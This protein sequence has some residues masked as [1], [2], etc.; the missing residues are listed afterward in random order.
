MMAKGLVIPVFYEFESP[1]YEEDNPR[2]LTEYSVKD[3]TFYNIDCTTIYEDE[4]DG[5]RKYGRIFSGGETFISAYS[6]EKLT[7]V[8]EKHLSKLLLNAN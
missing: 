7:S 3:I 1:M 4:D 8:I 5:D 6:P 2:P